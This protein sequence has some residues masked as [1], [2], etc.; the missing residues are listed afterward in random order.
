MAAKTNWFM[1][2]LIGDESKQSPDTDNKLDAIDQNYE[3]IEPF[4][5]GTY[6]TPETAP[7][8]R[9]EI[10]TTWQ[11]MQKEPTI[12]AALTLH[13]TAALGGHESRGDVLFMVASTSIEGET[14]KSK[15][16]REQVLAES[17]ILL[18][19][20]NKIVFNLCRGAIGYGDNFG[21]VYGKKGV[22][23]EHILCDD[24]T[25]PYRIQAYEQGGKTVGFHVLE[26]VNWNR[27]ITKLTTMQMCRMKMP[28]S[29]TVP[30][31]ALVAGV[32]K[33]MLENDDL[34][35]LP[36]VPSPVGG[37][38]LFDAEQPWKQVVLSISAMN[39]QQIADA[40][41][42]AFLTIDMAGMPPEQQEKYKSGL[43]KTLQN[44]KDEIKKAML[45]G[46]ALWATKYHVLPVWGDKQVLNPVGELSQRSGQIATEPL[47]INIRRMCGAL[48]IDMAMLGWADMLAGG[49][50]DGA[51]F[52]TS[53]QVMQRSIMIRQALTDFLNQ[54]A[55]LH[56]GWKYGVTFEGN[57]R[58][59]KWEFYSDMSA[60]STEAL[61]NKQTR[62][63]TM[64]L[65]AQALGALKEIGLDAKAN[66][67]LLEDVGGYDTDKA[68]QLSQ[69]LSAAQPP[70][71][72]GQ[73]GQPTG[74]D[75]TQDPPVDDGQDDSQDDQTDGEG[76]D[77]EAV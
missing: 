49:L 73:D 53:A 10:Y 1:K 75:A 20:L 23:V 51:S 12:A 15:K 56:W 3:L 7:R 22:G 69:A 63:N 11:Q 28:R 42:Q 39:S 8:T 45:G 54:V 38:F 57:D 24:L 67:M 40:V 43:V 59:W 31:T 14:P 52:H 61:T 33:L 34:E 27:K 60:A 46:E 2:F 62:M 41:R 65:T 9:I 21:R 37:S 26:E 4:A 77:N 13:T 64:A 16:L 18:P 76:D 74:D 6:Q 71:Q 44:S 35:T 5:L 58:P 66:Q 50:G 30:Q 48:G 72:D 55:D 32:Q 70:Q 19:I 17:K 29:C 47:M 25:A 68:M 36:I